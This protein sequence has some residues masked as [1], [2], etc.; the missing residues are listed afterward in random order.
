MKKTRYFAI[1]LTLLFVFSTNM[2]ISAYPEIT[3]DL[4]DTITPENEDLAE[5]L[6]QEDENEDETPGSDTPD[7]AVEVTEENAA[8]APPPKKSS[9]MPLFIGAGLA[10]LLFIGVVIYCKTKTKRYT[11]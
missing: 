5:A 8:E 7:P 4:T 2:T 6:I 10:V 9:N 11:R 3:E 1:L